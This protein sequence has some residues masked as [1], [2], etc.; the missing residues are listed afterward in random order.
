MSG[1]G[2]ELGWGAEAEGGGEQVGRE[3]IRGWTASNAW[4]QKQ[5]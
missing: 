2:A 5:T 1:G 3:G 4:V